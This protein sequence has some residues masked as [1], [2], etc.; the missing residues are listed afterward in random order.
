MK[1][2]DSPKGF[3]VSCC[4]SVRRVSWQCL[5]ETKAKVS[6]NLPRGGRKTC[7][8]SRSFPEWVSTREATLLLF[9]TEHRTK[10]RCRGRLRVHAR[11]MLEAEDRGRL[12]N[13]SSGVPSRKY[14]HSESEWGEEGGLR[15]GS[16]RSVLKR[17]SCHPANDRRD[18]YR[19]VY[20]KSEHWL[21]LKR[22]KLA[23]TPSCESCGAINH[24]DVHHLRYGRLFDVGLDDLLTL[25]RPCHAREHERLDALFP[26]RLRRKFPKRRI[27]RRPTS[28]SRRM[29]ALKSRILRGLSLFSLFSCLF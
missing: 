7:P 26:R 20:L 29:S 16:F 23:K 17:M 5:P 4:T 9:D 11:L 12:I 27:W 15:S 3:V 8:P 24:L 19:R 14:F 1:T 6:V 13:T 18:W 10:S 25:C 28:G 22:Q 21:L 2:L